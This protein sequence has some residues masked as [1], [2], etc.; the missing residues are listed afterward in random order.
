MNVKYFSSA[1]S[2]NLQD[3]ANI[4]WLTGDASESWL[5]GNGLD[6]EVLNEVQ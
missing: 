3:F 4:G 5:T 1:I 2:M 6:N